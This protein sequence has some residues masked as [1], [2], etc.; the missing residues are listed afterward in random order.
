MIVTFCKE[1]RKSILH[2][3][4]QLQLLQVQKWSQLQLQT[5]KTTS[6]TG[7]ITKQQK[8]PI[9]VKVIAIATTSHFYA[10]KPNTL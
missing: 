6:S 8:A 3:F 10:K 1:K 9:V 4:L 5:F 2:F 7:I